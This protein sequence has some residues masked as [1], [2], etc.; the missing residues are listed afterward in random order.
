MKR[1]L[2]CIRPV[3]FILLAVCLLYFLV[4]N[5]KKL[6]LTK[7]F[8]IKYQEYVEMYAN[9]YNLDVYL[10]YSIIKVESD[11][12][13]N[14]VSTADAKGLMQLMDKT[15]DDIN[16]KEGFGFAI[17]NDLFDPQKNIKL[18]CYYMR[19]LIDTYGSM[20]LAVTAYNG[21]TGNVD[22]WLKDENYADGK[23]G[24]ADIPYTET[25]KYV[26]KVLKTYEMYNKIYKTDE[27]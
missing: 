17:P 20:E 25:K 23:G 1:K 21:G 8:P 26:K 19:T 6:I 2:G 12:D 15:A 7:I 5:G 24:L 4:G 11:F 13:C 27:I 22:K 16:R 3:L 18:G 9:E 10:V 14:A